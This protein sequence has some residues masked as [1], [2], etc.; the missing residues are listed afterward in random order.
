MHFTKLLKKLMTVLSIFIIAQAG[1]FAQENNSDSDNIEIFI[2]GGYGSDK[3]SA[4][5][6]DISYTSKEAVLGCEGT[7][8]FRPVDFF[9]IGVLLGVGGT[10]GLTDDMEMT[11]AFGPGRTLFT[12]TKKGNNG[13][14]LTWSYYM[15]VGPAIAFYIA[16]ILR[17]EADFCFTVGYRRD[18]S[19]SYKGEDED[20]WKFDVN[21][22]LKTQYGGFSTGVQAKLFPD[23][24]FGPIIGWRYT[25]GYSGNIDIYTHP[26]KWADDDFN[27]D[28]SFVRNTFYVGFTYTI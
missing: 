18:N 20:G 6:F 12:G 17:L 10:V 9:G 7:G 27:C 3:V 14:G 21:T 24:S 19:F 16:D 11:D 26:S 13:S 4:D 8:F 28:Y 23:K 22:Y 2:F 5:I 1:L 15:E 25:K